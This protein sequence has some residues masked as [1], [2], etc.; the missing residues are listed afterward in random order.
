MGGRGG[1]SMSGRSAGGLASA[2]TFDQLR[3]H[4]QSAYGIRL[5]SSID[6]LEF[7]TARQGLL[8]VEDVLKELPQLA[9][10]IKYI[11][12]DMGTNAYAYAQARYSAGE[13]EFHLSMS[14]WA[15]GNGETIKKQIERDGTFHPPKTT[16]RSMMAHEVGHIAEYTLA[17]RESSS[18]SAAIGV[19]KKRRVST[20]IVGAACKQVKKTP[21][22]KGKK[23][24]ELIESVSGYASK[25]RSEALAECVGDYFSNGKSSNPLSQAVWGI[26]KEKLG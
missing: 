9:G 4:M 25:N 12:A 8:G 22:G 11:D 1:S 10:S 7:E 5:D 23:N 19:M 13:L 26:L 16:A 6:K 2:T 17:D 24:K 20:N 21:Y 14:G 18:A 15:Y 3:Q